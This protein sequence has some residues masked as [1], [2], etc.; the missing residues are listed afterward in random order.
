MEPDDISV[1]NRQGG[2]ICSFNIFHIYGQ[3]LEL[4]VENVDGQAVGKL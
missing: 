2:R 3:K 4:I 1:F